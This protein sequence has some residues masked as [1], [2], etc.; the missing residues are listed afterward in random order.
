L[1]RSVQYRRSPPA[2]VA[3]FAS[4]HGSNLEALFEALEDRA[5][6]VI[7]LV[8]SDRAGARALERARARGVEAVVLSPD[9]EDTMLA[10]L[11]R[12]RVDWIVLAGYLKR[13]PTGVV[14]RYRNRILNIHP[15]LLP[16]HGGKGMYGERV[17]RA[18][19]EAGESTSGASVHLVDEEYDR[20]PVVAQESVAVL[21][22]D[23]P[24][25]LAARVLEIEHRLLPAVVLAAAEGR[26]RVEGERAWIETEA[27]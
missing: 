26:I 13:V 12:A 2:R 11:G 22:E 17:H 10:A 8:A 24:A 14:R 16:A 15:A 25:T 7:V 27:R 18:V 23:T 21:P 20:G 3:V 6:A 5:E 9:D 19:I 4:G 1:T